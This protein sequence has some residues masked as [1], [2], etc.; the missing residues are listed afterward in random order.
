MR[1]LVGI[2]TSDRPSFAA[3]QLVQTFYR[4]SWRPIFEDTGT[5]RCSSWTQPFGSLS[6]ELSAHCAPELG[7]SIDPWSILFPNDRFL[8]KYVKISLRIPETNKCSWHDVKIF[9]PCSFRSFK[10]HSTRI[11]RRLHLSRT[12]PDWRVYQITKF[13]YRTTNVVFATI[14]LTTILRHVCFQEPSINN[15]VCIQG[16]IPKIPE[17]FNILP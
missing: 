3:H 13:K 8:W 10:F 17:T 4:P 16:T 1:S 6:N 15:E 11:S 5:S 9:F 7:S 12:R 2:K 14:V